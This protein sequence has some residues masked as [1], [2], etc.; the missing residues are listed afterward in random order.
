MNR[1]L[2][3][4]T[5]ATAA[6]AAAATLSGCPFATKTGDGIIDP[7][8]IVTYEPRT[9][10]QNLLLNLKKAYNLR[11]T[12]PYESLLATDFEFYFSEEDQQIAEK[13]TRDQE[14]DTHRNMCTSAQVDDISLEFPMAEA[15]LDENKPDPKYPD[16]NLWTIVLTNVDLVL[17]TKDNQGQSMTY[18]LEDGIEQFWFREESWLDPKTGKNIW[19]IVQW[20]ELTQLNP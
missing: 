15:I 13:L 11:E 5:L 1:A 20:K 17:R 7:H 16:R 14:I 10:P 12:A 18:K 8:P 9:S 19:T 2:R 3:L 6:T 4:L